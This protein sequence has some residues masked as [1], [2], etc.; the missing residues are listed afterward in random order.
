MSIIKEID[1]DLEEERRMKKEKEKKVKKDKKNKREF[2][3][4]EKESSHEL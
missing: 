3:S 4:G 2:Y 1:E